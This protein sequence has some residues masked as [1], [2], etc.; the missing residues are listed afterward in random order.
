MSTNRQIDF[1]YF[2]NVTSFGYD[3]NKPNSLTKQINVFTPSELLENEKEMMGIGGDKVILAGL[4]TA[5]VFTYDG[6]L[7][8][9]DEFNSSVIDNDSFGNSLTSEN[10]S[11]TDDVKELYDSYLTKV[12]NQPQSL[13]GALPFA[14]EFGV[15]WYNTAIGAESAYKLIKNI[16][17]DERRNNRHAI[18]DQ[19]NFINVT[20][21]KLIINE[22]EVGSAPV[23]IEIR[24][25]KVDPL[26]NSLKWIHNDAFDIDLTDPDESNYYENLYSYQNSGDKVIE[27][28]FVSREDDE[29]L[30]HILG[31]KFKIVQIVPQQNTTNAARINKVQVFASNILNSVG[32]AKAVEDVYVRNIDAGYGNAYKINYAEYVWHLPNAIDQWEAVEDIIHETSSS[33]TENNTIST[34]VGKMKEAYN[35]KSKSINDYL[36]DD[37][38]NF[39]HVVTYYITDKNTFTS[40]IKDCFSDNYLADSA[41]KVTWKYVDYVYVS[42][43][44]YSPNAK[45]LLDLY[46]GDKIY[47]A[48]RA[49]LVENVNNL[50]VNSSLKKE[51][52]KGG[53]A[54]IKENKVNTTYNSQMY[55][56]TNKYN[57]DTTTVWEDTY[58]ATEG[59]SNVGGYSYS[60][61]RT[62][63]KIVEQTSVTDFLGATMTNAKFTSVEKWMSEFTPRQI[64][65]KIN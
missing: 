24:M 3:I 41:I 37:G 48:V 29:L 27:K 64:K 1:K 51:R 11:Q 12:K 20:G 39:S 21:V 9:L 6:S 31:I 26:T 5:P 18:F 33:T 59:R 61:V 56:Y 46:F 53:I 55:E 44:C 13:S 8:K 40:D 25:L 17:L 62:G 15:T 47:A 35:N 7:M 45:E 58:K 34:Y 65:Y 10:M 30:K 42:Y 52:V 36:N 16:D 4:I 19:Y 22:D 38:S 23:K 28:Q 32:L 63:S 49:K 54:V 50:N 57:K 60:E 2:A 14:P 43:S